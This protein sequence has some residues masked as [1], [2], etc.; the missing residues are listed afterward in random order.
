MSSNEIIERLVVD[1]STDPLNPEKNLAIAIEY[2]K[3]G[4]TA[5]AVGF[6]LRAAEYGYKTDYYLTY[7]AL[8]RVSICIE[9]QKDRNLTVSNVILQAIAYMPERPEAYFLMSK[10][11]ERAESWQ[12]SYA[13]AQMGLMH[14]RQI[15]D[16][17]IDVGYPGRYALDFQSA[18][19]AWWIGRKSESLKELRDLLKYPINPEYLEAVKSNLERLSTDE[20]SI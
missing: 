8:L 16:L 18:V 13:F 12:E 17:P 6:Y 2:E 3:L 20:A 1:A 14:T 10:F 5:S 19:A 4:Q 11:H 15:F 9:G 7:A